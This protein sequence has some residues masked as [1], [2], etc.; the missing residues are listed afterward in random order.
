MRNQVQLSPKR[1][2]Q[3]MRNLFTGVVIFFATTMV[4]AQE[5]KRPPVSEK[6][7]S[8]MQKLNVLEGRWA[9]V[10]EITQDDGNTWQAMPASEVVI[11]LRHKGMILAEV[12]AD[13][14]TPGFHMETYI[15]YDQYRKVFRK[16]A[17]DDVWGIMDLYEGTFQ[18]DAIVF[19]N[20]ASGTTFPIA[21]GVW[22]NFRLRLELKSPERKFLIEKSDDAGQTW[23]PSFRITYSLLN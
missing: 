21:K 7:F 23:Q 8:M 3:V 15:T 12:P 9:M 18:E 13:T 19:D 17:I 6:P 1:M 22:R 20:V 10:T 14:S 4:D 2:D 5:S 16:A 11:Q